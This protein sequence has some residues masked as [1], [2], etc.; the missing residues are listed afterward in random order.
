VAP[1][2]LVVGLAYATESSIVSGMAIFYPEV[3]VPVDP[4][5]P[6]L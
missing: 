2:K 5:I 4:K 3:V 6:P 1:K